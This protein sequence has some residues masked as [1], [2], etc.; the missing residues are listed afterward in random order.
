MFALSKISHYILQQ[1]TIFLISLLTGNSLTKL[2]DS[3]YCPQKYIRMFHLINFQI[4]IFFIHESI[5]CLYGS[6]H[7][8]IKFIKLIDGKSQSRQ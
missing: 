3:P 1:R 8:H 2:L 4:R 7:Y 5:N 6:M